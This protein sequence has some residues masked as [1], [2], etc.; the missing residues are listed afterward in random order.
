MSMP[1]TA[2]RVRF[3]GL[4]NEYW[5]RRWRIPNHTQP[6]APVPPSTRSIYVAK[7]RSLFT[8]GQY[9]GRA[10][11]ISLDDAR[12]WG[13]HGQHDT[14]VIYAHAQTAGASNRFCLRM[15]PNA[16]DATS[17]IHSSTFRVYDRLVQDAKF[18]STYLTGAE[19]SF[20]PIH[21]GMWVME[22]GDWAGKVL[23]SLTQW[24]GIPWNELRH[25]KLD[26]QANRILVGRA[27]EALHDYGVDHGGLNYR[28][29][30][31]HVLIDIFAP[32][33]TGAGIMNGKAPCY[34]V[35]FSEASAG[36]LCARKLP[37]LPLD[38]FP[39]TKEVGCREIADLLILLN[40]TRSSNKFSSF[41]SNSCNS[42]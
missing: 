9:D 35:D 6:F 41:C 21:Y 23:F 14:A 40:F 13:L 42:F 33:L 7:V 1:I 39:D 15:L 38:A 11:E 22:T 29:D 30:F 17:N 8:N 37:V 31:R 19:G 4:P 3:E 10:E 20:V 25:T 28:S 34:I 16:V 27:F 32:G 5:A 24:C 12:R 2:F 18:H 36:H 26:T